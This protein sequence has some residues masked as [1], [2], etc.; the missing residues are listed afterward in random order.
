MISSLGQEQ[1]KVLR[2]ARQRRLGGCV[3]GQDDTLSLRRVGGEVHDPRPFGLAQERQCRPYAV[4]HPHHAVVEGASPLIVGEVFE[5][6]YGAGPDRIDEDVQFASPP[7]T[8]FVEY[9][10]NL[11]GVRGVG[12]QTECVRTSPLG[13][14]PRRVIEY[15]LCPA[16]NGHARTVGGKA[17]AAASPM[18]Q[19]PPTT[20]VA[21]ALNPRSIRLPQISVEK[22]TIGLTVEERN[23]VHGNGGAATHRVDAAQTTAAGTF[24]STN[25]VRGGCVRS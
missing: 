24:R 7:L 14:I 10:L 2:D 1:R 4:H 18:P 15:R 11:I 19:P 13:Q 12:D 25:P 16:D 5:S 9:T 20:T 17:P 8:Q 22:L 21:A 23:G 3:G 6:A